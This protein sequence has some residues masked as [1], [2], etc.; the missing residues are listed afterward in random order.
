MLKLSVALL[1]MLWFPNPK[2]WKLLR[3]EDNIKLYTRKVAGYKI[4]EVKALTTFEASISTL[5]K[6]F[7]D[8]EG[9]TRWFD[10]CKKAEKLQQVHQNEIYARFVLHVPFP[11]KDRDI[12]TKIRFQHV[13]ANVFKVHVTN[14]PYYLPKRRGFVRTPHFKSTWIFETV[15]GGKKTK[16]TTLLHADMGGIIPTWVINSAIKWGPFL[17]LKKLRKLVER[18]LD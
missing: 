13:N 4:K 10:E 6:T 2:T 12:V 16:V 7:R 15:E 9:Y 3:D 5:E 18:K 14:H 8:I 1:L 11:L 17:S